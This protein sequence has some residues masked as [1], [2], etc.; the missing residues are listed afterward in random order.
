MQGLQ[1]RIRKVLTKYNYD[2]CHLAASYTDGYKK[3]LPKQ[4]I[5]EYCEYPF[6]GHTV[7]GIKNYDPYLKCMYGDYM[8]IPPEEKRIQHNFHYLDLNKPYKKTSK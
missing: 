8:T 6:E 1:R 7:M 2:T 4:I 3:I 5:D